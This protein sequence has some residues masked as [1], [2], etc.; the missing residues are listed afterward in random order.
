LP[1]AGEGGDEDWYLIGLRFEVVW[2]KLRVVILPNSL[3]ALKT[4]LKWILKINKI[5]KFCGM[6]ISPQ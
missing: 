5:F 1:R 4:L 2:W 3:N 6:S